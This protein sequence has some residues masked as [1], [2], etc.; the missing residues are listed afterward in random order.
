MKEQECDVTAYFYP[1]GSKFFL[2]PPVPCDIN[3]PRVDI[4][5]PEEMDRKKMCR[6]FTPE[7]VRAARKEKS[8]TPDSFT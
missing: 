8:K 6:K 5:T 7:E 1:D 3:T 4:L 2:G